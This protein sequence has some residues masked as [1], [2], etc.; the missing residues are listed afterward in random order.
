MTVENLA[1]VFAPNILRQADYDPDIEMS[2]TPVITV[3]IAGFIRCHEELFRCELLPFAQLQ[4]A[5][6]ATVPA[7]NPTSVRQNFS[8]PPG[9][10]LPGRTSSSFSRNKSGK[11]RYIIGYDIIA[12]SFFD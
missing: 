9:G 7:I 11:S 2:A 5:A 10:T 4:S 12:Y 1:S 6:L 8:E 3:T